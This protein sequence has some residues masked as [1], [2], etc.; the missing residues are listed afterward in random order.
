M[1]KIVCSPWIFI[2]FPSLFLNT[3]TMNIN[4]NF[5]N[6][7]DVPTL[8]AASQQSFLVENKTL[9]VRV[10]ENATVCPGFDGNI[11]VNNQALFNKYN[12]SSPPR[13]INM[14]MKRLFLLAISSLVG[15]MKSQTICGI[16]GFIL[17]KN[18]QI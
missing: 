11:W 12:T 17:M 9:K 14:T 8:L 6:P 1:K 4:T 7:N 3:P 5:I 10:Y 15:D 16:F 2:K 18:M 13:K